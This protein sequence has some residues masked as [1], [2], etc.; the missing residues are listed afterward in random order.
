MLKFVLFWDKNNHDHH[1]F[2]L[3]A[4]FFLRRIKRQLSVLKRVKWWGIKQL[5]GFM[6]PSTVFKT[7]AWGHEDRKNRTTWQGEMVQFEDRKKTETKFRFSCQQKVALRSHLQ[8]L[9]EFFAIEHTQITQNVGVFLEFTREQTL[10]GW[11]TK[12]MGW[13][14]VRLW[15]F[16]TKTGILSIFGGMIIVFYQTWLLYSTH[17]N[18]YTSIL[19]TPIYTY[20]STYIC[21]I[22]INMITFYTIRSAPKKTWQHL[23]FTTVGY[24]HSQVM[25]PWWS[26]GSRVSGAGNRVWG[27]VFFFLGGKSVRLHCELT[28][29][30]QKIKWVWHFFF[31]DLN[32]SLGYIIFFK[33]CFVTT[34]LTGLRCVLFSKPPISRQ[35]LLFEKMPRPPGHRLPKAASPCRQTCHP[36]QDGRCP[37]GANDRK[38]QTRSTRGVGCFGGRLKIWQRWFCQ[39]PSMFL[40]ISMFLQVKLGGRISRPTVVNAS[41][42]IRE[43]FARWFPSRIWYSQGWLWWFGQFG[44]LHIQANQQ[45][46][47]AIR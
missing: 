19:K 6:K 5:N 16:Y 13:I 45:V 1:H 4:C 46:Q 33:I 28:F 20:I 44:Q 9:G 27:E 15:K 8:A 22:Y 18:K 24:D 30:F 2:H 17:T 32:Y 29:F 31:E 42:L 14:L 3:L 41:Q 39:L 23:K 11:T 36:P 26:P 21:I 10:L 38:S 7:Q 35:Q 25:L 43:C 47:Y 37:G 40:G 34:G 12:N